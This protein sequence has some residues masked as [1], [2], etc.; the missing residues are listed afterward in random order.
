MTR[1]F[2]LEA[3]TAGTKSKPPPEGGGKKSRGLGTGYLVIA[4][5]EV[6]RDAAQVTWIAIGV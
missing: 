3:E 5:S 4:S 2:W 6:G 1:I